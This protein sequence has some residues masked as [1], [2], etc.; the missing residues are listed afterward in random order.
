[1]TYVTTHPASLNCI[2]NVQR[3]E[4]YELG[5]GSEFRSLGAGYPVLVLG[6]GSMLTLP[7]IRKDK[8]PTDMQTCVK[9]VRPVHHLHIE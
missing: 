4:E 8:R 5:V 9:D 2:L 6:F 3:K 1:M 7:G